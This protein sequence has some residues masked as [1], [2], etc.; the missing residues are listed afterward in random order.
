MYAAVP[1]G[2]KVFGLAGTIHEEV[3]REMG[4]DFVAELYGDVKY[5]ADGTLVID[6]TKKY[7]AF[8][9]SYFPTSFTPYSPCSYPIV[10]CIYPK[11]LSK[12]YISIETLT[13]TLQA[14]AARRDQKACARPSGEH[15]C[16]GGDGG[17]GA[18]AC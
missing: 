17:A 10:H 5:N 6:R 13:K 15:K 3:A 12:G 4:L 14:M 9:F 2:V 18:V 7:V 8:S 16:D 1:K 11:T